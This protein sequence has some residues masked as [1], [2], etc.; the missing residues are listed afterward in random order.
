[1]KEYKTFT[2]WSNGLDLANVNVLLWSESFIMAGNELEKRRKSKQRDGFWKT[3]EKPLWVTWLVT[4]HPSPLSDTHGTP[5]L[6]ENVIIY[7]IKRGVL[8]TTSNHD[9]NTLAYSIILSNTQPQFQPLQSWLY[10]GSCWQHTGIHTV[11]GILKDV[12][13][14][15]RGLQWF[16]S[17]QLCFVKIDRCKL[18]SCNC[19][20][21]FEERRNLNT[22][23]KWY[24]KC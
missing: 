5:Y 4:S 8:P 12:Q 1:M 14:W 22:T 20:T 6:K 11:P 19:L 2:R 10:F 16:M 9:L 7:L 21:D 13:V 24:E 3:E 15:W 18:R 17:F 23:Y